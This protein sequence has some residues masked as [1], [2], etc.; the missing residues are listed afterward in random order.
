M[1]GPYPH[2]VFSYQLDAPQG[3]HGLSPTAGVPPEGATAGRWRSI[4]LLLP[5]L[6]FLSKALSM[7]A[8]HRETYSSPA[9]PAGV[10]IAPLSPSCIPFPDASWDSPSSYSLS[11]TLR[12]QLSKCQHGVR[13]PCSYILRCSMH[14]LYVAF[15]TSPCKP[16][17]LSSSNHKHLN[18]S[19]AVHW[20]L[21]NC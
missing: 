11:H 13:V 15:T 18:I 3:A 7:A 10:L 21:S 12:K 2:L 19:I 4:A 6:P 14:I 8:T 9:H 5:E 20:I 16:V 1:A 17:S